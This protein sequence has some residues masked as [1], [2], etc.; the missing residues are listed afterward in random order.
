M[1]ETKR[2]LIVDDNFEVA[3]FL[4]T[5]LE[6]VWPDYTVV[7]V[8]SGEEGML[9]MRRYGA[10]LVIADL[11]LPGIHGLELIGQIRRTAPSTP[12]IVITGETS[13]RLRQQAQALN[14]AGFFLKPV[15]VDE[16]TGTVR[17]ILEGDLPQEPESPVT[18]RPLSPQVTRR[19]G[20][21]RIDTGAHYAML[22]DLDG[23]RLATDGQVSD[24]DTNRV[25]AVLSKELQSAFELA[26]I[27]KAPQPFTINYQ[28]GAVHDLYAANVGSEHFIALIFDAQRGRGKIGAVWVYARRAI[29]E[30][31]ELLDAV[32]PTPAA[33]AP[34]AKP[35]QEPVQE[36]ARV[37][38][39]PEP[40]APQPQAEL[41]LAF[42]PDQVDAFWDSVLSQENSGGGDSGGFNGL[43]LEEAR[44]RGL[45][46]ADF[47][48]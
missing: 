10:D 31:L 7:N 3:L 34:K 42:S 46:P 8:P 47:D 40:A 9:E 18:G 41:E 22:A 6:I 2:I 39:T 25:A 19:L 15:N 37:L 43:S 12:I 30:L 14:P 13:P 16:L 38:P 23:R 21:L 33:P 24:L 17:R 44:L 20:A 4:R 48:I 5:T 1:A 32:P 11:N 28:A 27:L 26:Q 29:K 36:P 45:I 35:V